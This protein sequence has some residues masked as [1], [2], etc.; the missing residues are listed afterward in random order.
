MAKSTFWSRLKKTFLKSR[1]HSTQGF[2][3]LELLVVTAIAGG[4]VAGLTYI[5]VQ[6]MT[7]DQR[8]ASRSE[9]Q[10]EMQLALD[11][12]SAELREAIYVYPGE[13]LECTQSPSKAACES[14]T[15]F[16]PASVSQNSVPVL[17]FWK[18]Q[19]FPRA[20]KDQCAAA[21]QDDIA[22][23]AGQ[24]YALVVYSLRKND[25]GGIWK[26]KARITR[27]M[28]S[29][30]DASGNR[31]TGYVDPGRSRNFTTWPYG[32]NPDN[33]GRFEN[34]QAAR[35]DGNADTLV[36]YVGLNYLDAGV[37]HKVT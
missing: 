16:L 10:R 1:H 3:L 25:V 27:Y 18:Q 37:K 26:G 9:T 21:E 5:V 7:A 32:N 35:P 30:F 36:D 23:L 4:I 14:I 11:Y 2:T 12:I 34:L 6:M 19:P 22:C 28:L 17:A 13:Y 20:V 8:E 33:D 29:Q 24:S 31:T 15:Q